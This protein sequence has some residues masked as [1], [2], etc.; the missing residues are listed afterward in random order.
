[1]EDRPLAVTEDEYK[2]LERIGKFEFS[3][4]PSAPLDQAQRQALVDALA[5]WL[6]SQWRHEHQ[7]ACS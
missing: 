1:M 4:R 5:R 2:S 6:L 7:E 3:V